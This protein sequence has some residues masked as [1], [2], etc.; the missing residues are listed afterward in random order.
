[1]APPPCAA[2]SEGGSEWGRFKNSQEDTMV[3]E[4]QEH[5]MHA[6]AALPFNEMWRPA[7]NRNPR[8]ARV[9]ESAERTGRE[10]Q[11]PRRQSE[12]GN[13]EADDAL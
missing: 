7:P 9:S 10:L 4:G 6:L 3:G 13:T 5:A 1:M 2:L 12:P 8:L 11:E